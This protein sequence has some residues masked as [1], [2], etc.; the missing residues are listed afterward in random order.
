MQI[1]ASPGRRRYMRSGRF[2]SCCNL[3]KICAHFPSSDAGAAFELAAQAGIALAD[4]AEIIH[5]TTLVTNAIIERRGAHEQLPVK[6]PAGDS[7]AAI[8][9]R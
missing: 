4:V 3:P 9:N 7:S 6:Q 8:H 1:A 2:R 5:G